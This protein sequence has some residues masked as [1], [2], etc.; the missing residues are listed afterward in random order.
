M[1]MSF[2][3]FNANSQNNLESL[4]ECNTQSETN[5]FSLLSYANNS[6]NTLL[7]RGA[8]FIPYFQPVSTDGIL[9]ININ[10][11]FVQKDDGTGN[12]DEYDSDYV[13]IWESIV[14]KVNQ[15]YANL[16]FPDE[17]CFSGSEE[18][19]I[20]NTKIQFVG[21][22]CYVRNSS[23]WNNNL[24]N[25][26]VFCPYNNWRYAV[27]DEEINNM[28]V[29]QGINVYITEDSL[30]HER[31]WVEHNITD[32]TFGG[33]LSYHSGGACSQFPN[34]TDYYRASYIH[35]PDCFAKYWY[36]RYTVPQYSSHSW[37]AVIRNWYIDGYAMSLA[38]ELGH[39]LYLYHQTNDS[40]PYPTNN[41]C[42]NSIMNPAGAAPHNFLP[43]SEI[44]RMYVAAM[45]TNIRNFIPTDTYLGV[46]ILNANLSFPNT[47]FYHS[48]DL[49][50][51][52]EIV[53]SC[54]VIMPQQAYINVRDGAILNLSN[55]NLHSVKDKWKG[56]IVNNGA[57][58][59]LSDI[60]ITDYDIHIK[61]GG[62]IIISG[63]CTISGDNTVS[64]DDGGYICIRN[65]AQI[66]LE[67][68][69]SLLEISTN[70][71]LGCFASCNENCLSNISELQYSGEG[72][73][74]TY[75]SSEDIQNEIIINDYFSSGSTVKVGYNVT[76]SKP[77]GEVKILS[78][79]HLRI[80]STGDVILTRDV[81]VQK[82][83]IME[84][85]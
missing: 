78:G 20:K 13:D 23:L 40:L 49:Q 1:I 61:N 36:M 26:G 80:K 8:T 6:C 11:I 69:F 83:G 18:D 54:D 12:F 77:E 2:V 64:V 41:L 3:C 28:N 5:E 21:H 42:I 60:S 9:K 27:L 53:F 10:L 82:G 15:I 31:Y 46:H 84:I 51:G 58:L 37:D 43:P 44:G 57:T 24:S 68:Q 35:L 30:L 62:C 79:G 48:L 55:C 22:R 19:M 67:N 74:V 32:T 65:D 59:I 81:E 70:S 63:N 17:N 38:H 16:V 25:G 7:N 39:S 73:V 72:H 50:Q 76:T 45:T 66:T 47:R 4:F 75:T 29:P 71:I 14:N 52:S 56:I 85:K 34:S 33:S